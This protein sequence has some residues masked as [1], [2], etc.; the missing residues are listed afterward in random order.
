MGDDRAVL[1]PHESDSDNSAEAQGLSLGPFH[2]GGPGG[3]GG[4]HRHL[5]NF[6]VDGVTIF[7]GSV[8]GSVDGRSAHI[9]L[10]WP[11]S[12]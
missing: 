5:A 4:R 7:G 1:A 2:V 10:S 8:G 12:P 3:M 9:V 6:R 11:T